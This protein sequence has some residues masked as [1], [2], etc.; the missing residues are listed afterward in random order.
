MR[1][2][3]RDDRARRGRRRAPPILA[4]ALAIPLALASCGPGGELRLGR[5]LEGTPEVGEANRPDIRR[6]VDEEAAYP[7]LGMVPPRPAGLDDGGVLRRRLEGLRTDVSDARTR[8]RTLADRAAAA[9]AAAEPVPGAGPDAF[10]PPPA[11]DLSRLARPAPPRLALLPETR[12]LIPQAPIAAVPPT[13]ARVVADPAPPSPV[14][15]EPA[16][17]QA[18]AP[19]PAQAPTQAPV[20]AP[21]PAPAA[22]P[23]PARAEP[24][25]PAA[26]PPPAPPPPAAPPPAAAAR[27][28]AAPPSAPGTQPPRPASVRAEAPAPPPPAAP[29]PTPPPAA[30]P[31]SPAAAPPLPPPRA[32]PD[33]PPAPPAEGLRVGPPEFRSPRPSPAEAFVPGGAVIGPPRLSPLPIARPPADGRPSALALAAGLPPGPRPEGPQTGPRSLDEF[34]PPRPDAV[35]E[36]VATLT[37]DAGQTDPA[38]EEAPLF[39]RV[40]RAQD[41]LAGALRVLATVPTDAGDDAVAEARTR[42]RA[43]AAA[44]IR[45]GAQPARVYTGL[46]A[47]GIPGGGGRAEIFLDY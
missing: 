41:R 34:R 6:A 13:A 25:P 17:A 11:P 24:S 14:R 31:A 5:A 44:L 12:E 43:V 46:A 47:G 10:L 37:F 30:A 42:A 39:E 8:E 29:Q 32:V 15:A 18:Q 26:A 7:H 16:P 4:A 23:P 27:S 19:S 36:L 22:E 20:R 45:A 28:E 35:T 1:H 3:T 38:P 21:A 2:R 40:A 33:A 9:A